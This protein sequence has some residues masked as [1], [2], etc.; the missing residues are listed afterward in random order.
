MKWAKKIKIIRILDNE[1]WIGNLIFTV[2][3]IYAKWAYSS[4][5]FEQ[6]KKYFKID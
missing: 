3:K 1:Y 6:I 4:F 5:N 2:I